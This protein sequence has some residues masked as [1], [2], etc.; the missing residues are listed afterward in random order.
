MRGWWLVRWIGEGSTYCDT[1]RHGE[2]N[3]KR[4]G[5][6]GGCTMV[7]SVGVVYVIGGKCGGAVAMVNSTWVG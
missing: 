3:M 4:G 6:D 1:E 7:S 5:W 2:C